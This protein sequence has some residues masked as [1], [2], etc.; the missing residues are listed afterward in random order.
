MLLDL[1]EANTAVRVSRDEDLVFQTVGVLRKEVE[2]VRG[3]NFRHGIIDVRAA[4]PVVSVFGTVAH[5]GIV[6]PDFFANIGKGG[7][8]F[9]RKSAPFQAKHVVTVIIDPTR[10]MERTVSAHA[11]RVKDRFFVRGDELLTLIVKNE[12]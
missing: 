1:I 5:R 12:G 11:V 4:Y 10:V 9:V 2:I 7:R 6:H 3:V 8:I